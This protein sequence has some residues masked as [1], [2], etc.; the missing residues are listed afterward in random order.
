MLKLTRNLGPM[1]SPFAH[2][3]L[4]DYESRSKARLKTRLES[5]AEAG[6][7]LGHGRSLRRGD[8]LS[9]DDGVLVRVEYR[10]EAVITARAGDGM[11]L[12]KGCYH[13]GNRHVPLQIG[14]LWLR[15]APDPVLERLV[16]RLG[17]EV[18]AETVPFE[19]EAG[20][21][22]HGQDEHAV[23]IGRE[24]RIY[25]EGHARSGGDG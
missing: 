16:R 24:F 14:E 11:L 20:A 19:P 13:L 8:I 2:R 9:T 18:V 10:P 4:L 7:F 1:N 25:A 6:L 21:Y 15:F 12:A 22:A 17:F 23:V 5:G 3:L